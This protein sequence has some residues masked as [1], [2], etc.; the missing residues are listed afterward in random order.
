MAKTQTQSKIQKARLCVSPSLNQTDVAALL[1]RTQCWLSL[2]ERGKL[3]VSTK[4]E[5]AI[6][7]AIGRLGQFRQNKRKQAERVIA[8]S[9]AGLCRDLRLSAV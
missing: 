1:G 5:S 4:T 6:L 7:V 9:E 8:E 2:I 3:R